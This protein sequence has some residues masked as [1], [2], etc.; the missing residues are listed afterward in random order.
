MK[1]LLQNHLLASALAVGLSLASA[2]TIAMT[3]AALGMFA[4][5]V[6]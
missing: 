2:I 3:A 5:W 4:T 1:A 6:A